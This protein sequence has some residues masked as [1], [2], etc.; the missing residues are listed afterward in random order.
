MAERFLVKLCPL[1][2]AKEINEGGVG[3]AYMLCIT[4]TT[5]E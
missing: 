5:A 2:M 1:K 4:T 3:S